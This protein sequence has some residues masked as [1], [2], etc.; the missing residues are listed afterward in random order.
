MRS[1]LVALLLLPASMLASEADPLAAC[2]TRAAEAVQRHY[3][4]AKDLTAEFVQTSRSV[5]AGG[6]QEPVAASGEV[7]LQVP[8]K[9]RWAYDKPEKSLVVSDG[10][11]LWLYDPGF[12]EAQK[13]PVAGGDYLS[14]AAMVFLRGNGTLADEFAIATNACNEKQAELR[15]TPREEATYE[16]LTIWVDTSTGLIQRTEVSD[17]LGNKTLVEFRN[18]RLDQRPD[19]SLFRFEPP[20][21]VEVIEVDPLG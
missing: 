1:L 6:L 16:F 5:G 21:G 14:G 3:G 15:L 2:G 10:E 7:I 20:E 12:K 8:G 18:V 9:M 19:D 4:S 13:L 17:L 11:T